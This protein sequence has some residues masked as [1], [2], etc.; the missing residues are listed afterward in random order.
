[1]RDGFFG[2]LVDGIDRFSSGN[3]YCIVDNKF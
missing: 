1:M 2:I 3:E